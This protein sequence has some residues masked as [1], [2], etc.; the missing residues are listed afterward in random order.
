MG[1]NSPY[2]YS[3]SNS[4]T[5]PVATN[6][7]AGTYTVYVTDGNG[8]LQQGTVVITQPT[9][10]NLTANTVPPTCNNANGSATVNPNG[11]TGP[12]TFVWNPSAQ[13]TVTAT[14]LSAG[15]YSVTVTDANGCTDTTSVTL[16]N[17]NAPTSQISAQTNE[18]CFGGNT[19][20]A[21]VT[22]NGGNGPYTYS[23]TTTPSQTTTTATGLTAG[24][25]TVVTT[26]AAGCTVSSVVTITEPTQIVLNITNGTGQICIGQNINLNS[27]VHGGS[28]PYTY[29]WNTGPTTPNINVSPT[30]TTSYTVTVTDVNG[31]TDTASCTITV[32]P[33]PVAT[34]TA[35]DTVACGS[36]CVT[37]GTTTNTIGATYSWNFGDGGTSTLQNPTLCYNNSVIYTVSLIVTS[38][39]GCSATFTNAIYITIHPVP[40]AAFTATPM[41]A[42]LLDPKIVFTDLSTGATTWSWTF[43]DVLNG[44]STQQNPTYTYQDTG[45]HTVTLIVTNQYG[46][47]D[48][49]TLVIH[50]TEEF[51]FYAPNSFTPSHLQG[52]NT[53]FTPKGVGIDE[54]HY[55][56]WIFDR[57][58]NMIF[59]TSTWG[60]GWDGR[61]NGGSAVAQEDVYVWLVNVNVKSTNE[62]KSFI[63]HVSL[64]K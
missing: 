13:T 12:Y 2:T 47:S 46:C 38:S 48:T 36:L 9:Q 57:W 7:S 3:W 15:N 27:N 8:C 52:G 60:V 63:G 59:H 25:Y 28:P 42:T 51:T 20:D 34:I 45:Y 26:D 23:W 31:C 22:A 56:L 33:L 24:N 1:G 49:A 62:E 40:V 39:A 37:F 11:G 44:T 58:G 35:S 43:G 53:V 21:T 30:T 50:I 54:N 32:N 29:A 41:S 19:G 64:I 17:S 16:I 61:A 55:D 6:L 4:Q 5:G 10:I 18:L 14:G